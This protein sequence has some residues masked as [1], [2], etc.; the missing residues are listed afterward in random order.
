MKT[1]IYA[2]VGAAALCVS[3][4][5]AVAKG[6]GHP[7]KDADLNGDGVIT[8]EEI[9]EHGA[10]FV[11][12]ADTDGDGAV[13]KDEA[14]A[15]RKKMMEERR[16]A[17]NPDVNDDG[18]IDRDEFLDAAEARFDAMDDNGDGV[19]DEDERPK[20]RKH[21]GGRGGGPKND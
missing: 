16:E 15:Y 20:H 8:A 3:I 11:A 14:R 6:H 18:V 13:S 17:R 5:V 21:K 9:A 19:I 10:E 7:G 2:G 12:N 1:L 4:G